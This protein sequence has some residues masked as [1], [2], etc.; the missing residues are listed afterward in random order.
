MQGAQ[1][2][3]TTN[4]DSAEDAC[5]RIKEVLRQGTES[6]DGDALTSDV[7]HMWMI[8]KTCGFWP[9]RQESWQSGS[10]VVYSLDN[11]SWSADLAFNTLVEELCN[12]FYLP[13]V[14]CMEPI[15]HWL[16]INLKGNRCIDTSQRDRRSLIWDKD[17]NLR[18][19][20]QG[21]RRA[22]LC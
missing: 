18:C 7:V 1:K 8:S 15:E 14:R 9:R 22:R 2:V 21:C 17:M 12:N 10:S 11:W 20:I 3:T 13:Q 4:R 5:V 19:L 16:W 6:D